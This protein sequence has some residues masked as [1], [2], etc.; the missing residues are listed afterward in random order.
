MSNKL[1]NVSLRLFRNYLQYKGLKCIR[2]S[3]GHEV[4]AGKCVNRPVILQTHIDPI[5]EFIVKNS[6]KNMGV[7]AQDFYDYKAK[8]N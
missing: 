2:I 6:L 8:L 4:W 3:G 7:T 1:K 5:P